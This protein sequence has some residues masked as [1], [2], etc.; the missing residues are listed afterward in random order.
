MKYRQLSY[1]G[2]IQEILGNRINI[3]QIQSVLSDP[4]TIDLQLPE[5]SKLL[6][7]NDDNNLRNIALNYLHNRAISD[8]II[9]KYQLYYTPTTI[10]FPYIEYGIIAYWQE[11]EILN[12]KFNF[13]D[14]RITGLNKSDYLFGFDNV[15]PNS[16]VVVVESIFNC[17]SIDDNCVATGGAIMTGKQPDKLRAL[18]PK[19]VVLCPDNDKAG[20]ESLK[21]NYFLLERDF[22]IGYCL[23]PKDLDWNDMD[24]QYGIG[25]ARQYIMKNKSFLSISE[26]A[27]MV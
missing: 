1:H 3:K 2:A 19:S 18:L 24:R 11:R 20:L 8:E 12:K 10:V 7:D 15:E 13:P 6:S 21:D 5:M 17:M 27:M 25:S 23:P 9:A 16:E 4:E 22:K 26:L 14:A